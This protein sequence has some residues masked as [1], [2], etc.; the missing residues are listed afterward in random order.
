MASFEIPQSFQPTF[1]STIK[2]EKVKCGHATVVRRSYLE[3]QENKRRYSLALARSSQLTDWLDAPDIQPV[4]RKSITPREPKR[5][6]RSSGL[7]IDKWLETRNYDCEVCGKRFFHKSAM[8]AH[9]LTHTSTPPMPRRSLSRPE[10][11][12]AKKV[13]VKGF[14]SKIRRKLF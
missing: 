11:D 7:S 12:K 3:K 13:S 14:V 9:T 5:L 2:P 10:T 1:T 4:Q 8:M 6:K